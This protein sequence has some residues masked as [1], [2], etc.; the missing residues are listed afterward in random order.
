VVEGGL[1]EGDHLLVRNGH[2]R[3]VAHDERRSERRTA[4]NKCADMLMQRSGAY[5]AAGN[6]A[7]VNEVKS[8]RVPALVGQALPAVFAAGVPDKG[9]TNQPFNHPTL[10]NTTAAPRR[11]RLCNIWQHT[12]DVCFF[13][14]LQTAT[15]VCQPHVSYAVMLKLPPPKSPAEASTKGHW[16]DCFPRSQPNCLCLQHSRPLVLCPI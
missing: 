5:A 2:G 7:I 3:V 1:C 14:S 8:Y 11:H 15:L 12:L 9:R 13:L 10:G 16:S 4:A 6:A